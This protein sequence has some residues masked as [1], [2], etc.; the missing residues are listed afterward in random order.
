MIRSALVALVPAL[1]AAPAPKSAASAR[2][3]LVVVISVDQFSAELM[4][5]YGPELSGGL[6]RLRREGV[7]FTEAYHDHGFTETG[8]GHSVLLSG[9]FPAHTGIVEN[10]W[11]D[12]ATGKLVYC[13]ED[14]TAKALHAPAQASASNARF[15]G[16]GLGDWLQAQVPGSR[17]FAVSGKDRAAI[18]LAGR[19]PTA[20]YWFTGP[21]G[22]T[23]STA[24]GDH[25][26]DWLLR[27]DHSLSERLATDSWLWSKDPGT[28]EGRTAQWTFG[29]TVVRNGALPRLVQGAGMPLDKGFETR[30]RRSPFLDTVTLEAAEALLNG[31]KLGHG[32]STD[33]LAISFSATDYIGHTYGSLGTEMRDQMHRLDR[34]LGRLLDRIQKQHPGAW[35]VLCADHG[36][37]DA[38]EALA[39][40]GFP[41]RRLLIEPFMAAFQADL[42]AAFKVDRDLLLHTPEP[43]DIYL[44]D[45]VVKAANLDRGDILRWAQAWLKARPEVA[46]AFTAEELKATD[47]AATGSPRD[48]SLRVLLRR[49]F[50]PE[51]SGDLLM[52]VKPFVVIGTPP[53]DYL[54]NHGTPNAYDR[55]VPMIFWGPWKGGERREPVRTVDLAPTLAREL[56]L[57]PGAVDGKALDLGPRK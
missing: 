45:A 55:R 41:A 54:T 6:A 16:D 32:P 39:D 11:I 18:L 26:P 37:V 14:A 25:L 10:R 31:E 7:F 12:R 34:V 21:A 17:V 27:Y 13:V 44:D 33:L 29:G 19:R 24:Y 20:A 23:S 8:P 38:P 42:R 4:Q 28:P 36:G 50:H 56:G 53:A 57:K 1:I 52:A 47:P 3:R 15:L 48:S 35:V 43:N 9:R 30:F 2:P 49:S 5:T 40:Q 22:F 46:D 51:R